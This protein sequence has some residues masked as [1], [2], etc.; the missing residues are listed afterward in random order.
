MPA[1]SAAR[2]VIILKV[3]PGGYWPRMHLL[4]SGV[5]GLSRSSRQVPCRRPPVNADG[6]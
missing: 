2:A 3:E 5:R 4:T 6:S 1:S